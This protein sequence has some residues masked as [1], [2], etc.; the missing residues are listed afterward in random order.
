MTEEE[1]AAVVEELT[2]IEEIT[3]E[4]LSEVVDALNSDSITEEQVQAIVDAV[5][6]NLDTLTEITAEV[7][8]EV[9]NVLE[10]DSV[11]EEQVQEIVD[12]ILAT[13]VTSDQATQLA[14]SAAVLE[15]I[16]GDQ[17]TEVFAS[18]DTGEL[19][20]EEAAAIVE[21][22]LEAPT[23][24]KEAFEEEINVFEGLGV[25]FGWYG[26]GPDHLE[27]SDVEVGYLDYD[28]LTG[29]PPCWSLAKRRRFCRV[30]LEH[31]TRSPHR[32]LLHYSWASMGALDHCQRS[33]YPQTAKTN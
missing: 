31:G 30:N 14:T 4:V 27:R 1:V 23:E 25:D 15:S 3:P 2:T 24:V 7:L 21:A 20:G 12:T 11:T 28:C 33:P 18:I 22:L 16:T 19:S 5:V 26:H 9:L 10:S 32:Q 6:E 13:D 29:R 8:D 17:A